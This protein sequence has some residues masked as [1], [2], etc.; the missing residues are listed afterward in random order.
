MNTNIK[1]CVKINKTIAALQNVFVQTFHKNYN[2]LCKNEIGKTR[3]KPE[4][5]V[6]LK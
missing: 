4:K 3:E 1:M 6:A 5:Q 2:G